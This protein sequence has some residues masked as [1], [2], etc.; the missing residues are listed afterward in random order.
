VLSDPP[1][2]LHSRSTFCFAPVHVCTQCHSNSSPPPRPAPERHVPLA[3]GPPPPAL[4]SPALPC[5]IYEQLGRSWRASL[6]SLGGAFQRL[7]K[8]RTAGRTSKLKATAAGAAASGGGGLGAPARTPAERVQAPACRCCTHHCLVLVVGAARPEARAKRQ[9]RR[10]RAGPACGSVGRGH[11]RERCYTGDQQPLR[12]DAALLRSSRPPPCPALQQE[13][14]DAHG[15][16][17]GRRRRPLGTRTPRAAGW[18][19]WRRPISR[20]YSTRRV[21]ATRPPFWSP[22]FL[23]GSINQVGEA[24]QG[25]EQLRF[26]VYTRRQVQ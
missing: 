24:G 14:G 3:A 25:M 18:C 2:A 5:L 13:G 22:V 1:P 20:L 4:P 12:Y 23:L 26:P 11:E 10:P 21:A 7:L 17:P 16:A 6:A 15:R 9:H 19:R 8:L